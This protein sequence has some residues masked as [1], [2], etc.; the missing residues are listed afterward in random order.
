MSR[1]VDLVRERTGLPIERV[2]RRGD[3][4]TV[5]MEQSRFVRMEAAEV[6]NPRKFEAKIAA[7]TG[8]AIATYYTPKE[9][10]PIAVALIRL[11]EVPS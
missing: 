2:E 5:L 3:S 1:E 7:R 6:F 11:A 9:W 8:L 4:F 10:R